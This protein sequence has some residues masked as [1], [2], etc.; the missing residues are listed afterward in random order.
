MF[1]LHLLYNHTL[2]KTTLSTQEFMGFILRLALHDVR[3]PLCGSTLLSC[4]LIMI[5]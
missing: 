5:Q 4:I 3:V 1:Q 2:E